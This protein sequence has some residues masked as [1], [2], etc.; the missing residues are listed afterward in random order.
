MGTFVANNLHNTHAYYS[1]PK[2]LVTALNGPA[3]GISAAFIAHS[4][5]IYAAP[6]AWIATPFSSLGLL[7][8]GSS[9]KAFVERLGISR[10]NEALLQ[11]RKIKMDALLSTGFVNYKVEGCGG[12]EETGKGIDT[13][14]FLQKVL[15]DIEDKLGPH[16]VTESLFRI[17]ELIRAPSRLAMDK[18]GLEEIWGGLDVFLKGVPQREFQKIANGE[19]RHKL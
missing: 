1:H 8:E 2:I 4:D 17:K 13:D 6:H 10:A 7:P 9:S 18:A 16:L 5:F 11:S 12:D 19:K 14:K 15:D 3:V